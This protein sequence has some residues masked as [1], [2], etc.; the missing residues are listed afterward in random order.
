MS[1]LFR[2][3]VLIDWLRQQPSDGEYDFPNWR[4]CLMGQYLVDKGLEPGTCTYTDM[5]GYP[6]FAETKPHTFGAALER[7]IGA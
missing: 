2:T 4:R 7:V 5:P 1:A 3:D 6:E